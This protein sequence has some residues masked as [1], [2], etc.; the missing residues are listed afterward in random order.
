MRLGWGANFGYWARHALLLMA[1][2]CSDHMGRSYCYSFFFLS[3]FFFFLISEV[4]EQ[5][6]TK[7]GH[8]FTYDCYLK[9]LVRPSPGYLLTRAGVKNAFLGSTLKFDRT[10]LCNGAW[11]RQSERILWIYRDYPKCIPNLVNFG[12][13]T[14]E[15]SW[16][17]F[18][19]PLNF[20]IGRHCQ[21]N[22]MDII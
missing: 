17:V 22:H 19:H 2:E 10:Y 6:S 1:A 20:R 7:L 9:N 14:A 18:A 21:P 16:R 12:P 15:N 8:I 13:E 11:Y 3:S 4:T 5:I